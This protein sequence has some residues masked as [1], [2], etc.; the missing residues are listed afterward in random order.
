M[1]V[2]AFVGDAMSY[3]TLGDVDRTLDAG[4]RT[5]GARVMKTIEGFSVECSINKVW[6]SEA[7]AY[8]VDEAVQVFGGNGYSREFPVERA[9]RDARIT[10]IYEGTNEINRLIIPTRL[11]KQAGTLFGT[12]VP[13]GEGHAF[14]AEHDLLARIK[15]LAIASLGAAVQAT[16]DD[17]KDEQEVLAHVANMIIESYAIESG[18]ARAEKLAVRAHPLAAVA[19][20]IARVYT[21]DAGDRVAHAGKQILNAI[22]A[23]SDRTEALTM[24]LADV[25]RHP[26]IDTVA[27]RRRVGDAA[28]AAGRYPF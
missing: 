18:L 20:D 3:R 4:D 28:I 1:A 25:A 23:R 5:D 12:H 15:R 17:V 19:A 16:G 27:A 9:Y 22:A 7:L 26:G 14:M 2:R 10:R 6:T 13:A 21:A 8:V 11:L 24:D